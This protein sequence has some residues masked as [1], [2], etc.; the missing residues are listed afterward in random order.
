M[1]R[2]MKIQSVITHIL[3]RRKSAF[4]F[5][6]LLFFIIATPF[7]ANALDVSLSG[8]DNVFKGLFIGLLDLEA[9]LANAA[10]SIF[11]WILDPASFLLIMNNGAFYEIWKIVRDTMNMI[12]IL[13][14][15]FSAFATIYQID[16]YKYNKI[17]WTVIIMALLV[18]FS[19]PI[20][21][22]V[23]DFF[24][25]MMYFF[26][27]SVFRTSGTRSAG[28]ILSTTDL[29]SIFLPDREASEWKQIFLAIIVMF[30]FALTLLMLAITMLVRLIALPVLVMLSPIGFAGMAAPI[31]HKYANDWWSKLF[32]YASYGPISVFMVLAS[33]KILQNSQSAWKGSMSTAV[34]TMSANTGD[35]STAALT[36]LVY[37][38]IPIILF[39]MA[40]K[41]AEKMSN[42]ISGLSLQFGTKISKWAGKKF[43]GY[44]FVKRRVDAFSAERKKRSDEKFKK[45]WGA[46]FGKWTNQ[47]QDSIHGAFAF[48]NRDAAGNVTG[49]ADSGARGLVNGLMFNAGRA[50]DRARNTRRTAREEEITTS[51]KR[52]QDRGS[53]AVDL[54]INNRS[55]INNTF[56]APG[57]TFTGNGRLSSTASADQAANAHAYLKD[58][59]D[60]KKTMI[61]TALTS[62]GSVAASQLNATL[63]A[64]LAQM[65][66]SLAGLTG[67]AHAQRTA[68][69]AE[70]TNLIAIAERIADGTSGVT[71]GT[72]LNDDLRRVTA[73]MDRQAQQVVSQSVNTA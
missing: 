2:K 4:C 72:N 43:S 38:S 36:T 44:N 41:S 39:W 6:L 10:A 49:A 24:N 25:S 29:S 55:S 8:L 45:N 63:S 65:T 60:N 30:I 61:E 73:F 47:K 11:V 48:K 1:T 27:E 37:F 21:R 46:S 19:W 16:K 67:V 66:A 69:I 50:Y 17:L 12:F 71:P 28:A 18:N 68:E 56:N 64:G 5:S 40:I 20:A 7:S 35:I 13:V 34:S 54:A 15:L 42:E 59:A 70:R 52:L 53:S 58:S 51:S 26:V 31:T 22:V 32:K 14:L 23:V 62:A 9:I 3:P 33:V 57:A